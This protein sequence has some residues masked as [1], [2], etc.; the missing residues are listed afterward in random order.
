MSRRSPSLWSQL[1]QSCQAPCDRYK[2]ACCSHGGQVYVLG[3]REKH[4]LRDFWR[5]SV[6]HN[7]WTE[8]DCSSEAAPEELEEH[9]MVVHQGFIYV[10]GGMMDSAYTHWKSALWVFDIGKE[11]WV[12]WQ[13]M[14]SSSQNQMP[15]NRKGHS[16]VMFSSTMYIYGGYIDMRGSS[17]EFWSFDFD[18]MLWS[19]LHSAQGGDGPGPRH[20]HSAISHLDNMYLYGGLR[21]LREQKDLWRWSST[22]HTWSCLKTLSG[23]SRLLGH[24]AVVYRDNMLLFGGGESLGTPSNCLWRYSF[25]SQTWEKLTAL[26]GSSPPSRIH[27]CCV[28]LGPSYQSK[29]GTCSPTATIKNSLENSKLRP[30]KNKCFPVS[31]CQGT[32]GAIELETFSSVKGK[33][34]IELGIYCNGLKGK[35]TQRIGNC[36]TFENQEASSKQWEGEESL[37]G[38]EESITDHLPDLLLVLG[39]NSKSVHTAISVWHMTLTDF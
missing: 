22:R 7:Q 10:F 21:G 33:S 38:S 34:L 32:E 36:L 28:G 4:S 17:Q 9:S 15:V 26:P 31:P 2:H 25:T 14:R 23:P 1:P 13:G 30:F 16:A 5:Y 39:G 6:V 12:H 19:L 11:Q 18:T 20:N 3:G 29:T 37:V 24:S 27:H 8:L 35:D